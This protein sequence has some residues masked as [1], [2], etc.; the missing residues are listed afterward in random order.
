[1]LD[2]MPRTADR[3]GPHPLDEPRATAPARATT[4]T[5]GP[6]AAGPHRSDDTRRVAAG[7][8]VTLVLAVLAVLALVGAPAAQAHNVLRSTDP[9]DGATLPS[10]PDRVVLTF[11]AAATALGTEV[12]VTA[13]D[14]RVVSSGAPTLADATV[15]QPLAG[16]LPAGA[17]TVLWRVTSADGHPI[18]G[19]FGFV[20]T[21]ATVAGTGGAPV[22]TPTP[23]PTASPTATTSP[24]PNASDATPTPAPTAT[25]GPTDEPEGS[26]VAGPL[27]VGVGGALVLAGGVA[28]G[29]LLRRRPV[30][31]PE[32]PG[33]QGADGAPDGRGHEG[34]TG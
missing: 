2:G 1:M 21:A 31:G 20:A 29:Y 18:E 13:A 12:V 4:V 28:A 14:G 24:E 26:A 11:D 6:S 7:L 8:L 10:A 22:P 3:P 16:E 23:T 25:T 17:Y 9:A 27:L 34:P 15:T 32:T 5:G 19:T 30:D 33:A